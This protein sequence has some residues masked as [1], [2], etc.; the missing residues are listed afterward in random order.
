M[1]GSNDLG[2]SNGAAV[3]PGSPRGDTL[4]GGEGDDILIGD[5]GTGSGTPDPAQAILDMNPV[6]YWRL[7]E[8]SGSTAVDETG[9]Q[10]GAYTN[11]DYGYASANANDSD[12]GVDLDGSG[13][14][15]RIPH[16]SAFAP[17][18]GTIQLW[19][20]ADSTGGDNTLVSKVGSGEE[21]SIRITDGT[22]YAKLGDE[23]SGVSI[24]SNEWHHLSFSWGPSGFELYIDGALVGSDSSDK[25][26][27]GNSADFYLGR[28]GGG[29]KEFDGTIDEFVIFDSQLSSTEVSDLYDSGLSGIEGGGA[30]GDDDTLIGGEGNDT[31]IGGAGADSL[32]GGAGIDT[33]DYSGSESGVTVDL[34]AGTGTG[35]DAE[36]DTLTSI[37]N[38]TGSAHND[39]LTGDAGANTLEAVAAMTCCTAAT[40]AICSSMPRATATTPFM[41]GLVEAGPTRSNSLASTAPPTAPIGPSRSTPAPSTRRWVTRWTCRTMRPAQS[42]SPV[43][44][45]QLISIRSKRSPGRARRA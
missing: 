42:Q 12:T 2:L 45:R 9:T 38:V 18:Q 6:G 20:N 35:G 39:T 23:V 44:A 21:L 5:G 25:S 41:V 28:D 30:G 33:A 11:V 32:D 37:E 31:L 7:G 17:S 13:D 3:E 8:S 16:D 22:I 4:L 24:S 15:V 27:S 40:V 36:G 34:S 14:Y 26:L 10:N 29:G 19:F 43:P 1:A